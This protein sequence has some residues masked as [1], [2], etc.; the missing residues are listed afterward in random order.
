MDYLWNWTIGIGQQEPKTTTP[1]GDLLLPCRESPRRC[2]D[3]KRCHRLAADTQTFSSCLT[4]HR[5]RMPIKL[6]AAKHAFD[7]AAGYPRETVRDK[8]SQRMHGEVFFPWAGCWAGGLSLLLYS[9]PPALIL[10][11]PYYVIGTAQ[12]HFPLH[13]PR[14]PCRGHRADRSLT[15]PALTERRVCVCAWDRSLTLPALT[16]RLA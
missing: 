14:A 13:T 3:G 4:G 5:Y 2:K 1:P 16:E 11:L 7:G 15:P 6:L 10:Y 8:R 9:I 12:V